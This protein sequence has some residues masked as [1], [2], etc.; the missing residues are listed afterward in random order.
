MGASRRS[1]RKN[2]ETV[3]IG[4]YQTEIMYFLS[5]FP[6]VLNGYF[7]GLL[8]KPMLAGDWS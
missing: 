4:E 3:D 6:S 5:L 7:D 8:R 1:L 2:R